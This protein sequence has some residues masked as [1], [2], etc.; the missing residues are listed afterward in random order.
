MKKNPD[1]STLTN[2]LNYILQVTG[3]KK[4]DLARAIDVKPQIIQF[5]CTS[6]TRSS[7][8]TFEIATALGLNTRWLA[9]G[10]GNIFIADDSEKEFFKE[11]KKIPVYSDSDLTQ[12]FVKYNFIDNIVA[13]E[14]TPLK[15]SSD[16][17]FAIKMM[18]T[19]MEPHIPNGSMVFIENNSA[20][21]YKEK[22]FIFAYLIQFNTFVVRE[23][24][25]DNESVFLT[26]KN[27]D[28]F[29]EIPLSQEVK[30]IGAVTD[31]FWHLRS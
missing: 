29:K 25:M 12:S 19:S 16:N 18:D 7:R 30:I 20:Y 27:T 6:Q 17:I 11:F 4:A 24:I 13:E 8:F 10:E 5:L 9:T 22:D 14:W 23:I 31:C 3:T 21:S 15:T 26:P 28:L 2:R 1:L